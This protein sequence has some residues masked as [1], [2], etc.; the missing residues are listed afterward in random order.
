MIKISAIPI[1]SIVCCSLFV[2]L[3]VHASD[4]L[5]RYKNDQG[6]RVI[7]DAISPYYATKGYEIIDS[8]GNVIKTVPKELSPEE[9]IRQKKQRE[10]QAKLDAWDKELRSRYH[11]VEDIEST[12]KRRLKGVDN[13]IT[14]LQLTLQNIS[15]T[16]K[17]YQ[18]E[19]ASNERQGEA[20]P[21]DTL[22]SMARLQKDR[23]FIENEIKK[24]QENR[25][26]I[27][28]TFDADVA[29]FK[30]ILSK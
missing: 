22:S 27:V 17:Y 3:P 29:R 20:V 14:S 16:V 7:S 21:Q 24:R 19:A 10:E 2:Q 13:S 1:L 30:I 9:K 5:Y 8:R 6:G 12:R 26:K 4:T 25:K 23:D 15:E 28:D 18:A 11:N